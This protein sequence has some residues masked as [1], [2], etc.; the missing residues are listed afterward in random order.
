MSTAIS[1]LITKARRRINETSTVFHESD[2]LVAY[3]DEAQ[4]YTVR[5]TK[6]LTAINTETTIISSTQG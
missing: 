5:K 6:C 3:A 1:A 2:D 4:K